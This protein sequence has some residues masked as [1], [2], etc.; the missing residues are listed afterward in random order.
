MKYLWSLVRHKWFVFRAGL[1]TK[2]PLW[3]LVIHD[4]TKLLPWEF[5]HYN[6]QWYGDGQD[7]EGYARAWLHHQNHNPHHWEYWWSRDETHYTDLA[8]FTC[9]D[10]P[11]H[12]IREMVAD[13]MGACRA[14]TGHWPS[15][16]NWPWWDTNQIKMGRVLTGRTLNRVTQL[17][18]ECNCIEG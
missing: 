16:G 7:A 8:K 11:E 2:A 6:R 15:P 9:L 10:M 4:W 12:F 17:L 14:Y 13:W 5:R 3:R 18:K 1:K